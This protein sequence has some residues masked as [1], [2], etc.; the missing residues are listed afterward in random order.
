[1]SSLLSTQHTWAVGSEVPTGVFVPLGG[2]RHYLGFLHTWDVGFCT[3]SHHIDRSGGSLLTPTTTGRPP[4]PGPVLARPHWGLEIL[5]CC[6]PAGVECW[7]LSSP[8][9]SPKP[10][11]LPSPA[12]SLP[13]LT[14]CWCGCQWGRLLSTGPALVWWEEQTLVHTP[15]GKGK[16][17]LKVG[18]QNPKL[19]PG[20]QSHSSGLHTP[21]RH[22]LAS[23]LSG[24]GV[25]W[26]SWLSSL[27]KLFFK[28]SR[29]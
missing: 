11:A 20:Q 25:G 24:C 29:E 7:G 4:F 27:L 9:Q 3:Q 6:R 5:L 13:S 2:Q 28:H 1:M 19:P 26:G 15:S 14:P 21:P 16:A 22:R 23:V 12:S 8:S 17:V 10:G 18:T